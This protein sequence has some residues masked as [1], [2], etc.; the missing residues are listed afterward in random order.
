MFVLFVFEDEILPVGRM[1]VNSMSKLEKLCG[2]TIDSQSGKP[3]PS[4]ADIEFT[5]D[6]DPG[7][8]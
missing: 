8:F 2:V 5:L 4:V 3:T 6:D 1:E 7:M